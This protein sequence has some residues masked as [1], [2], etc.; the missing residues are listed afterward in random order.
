MRGGV[1]LAPEMLGCNSA[2]ELPCQIVRARLRNGLRH[3][4]GR[5]F[6]VS[7][8]AHDCADDVFQ[9]LRPVCPIGD[10]GW[11]EA[12]PLSQEAPIMFPFL[13][14]LHLHDSFIRS[15]R[16]AETVREDSVSRERLAEYQRR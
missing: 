9:Q 4:D 11:P 6:T 1:L 14:E 8:P 5:L 2:L 10:G 7:L 16:A 15:P 12:K 13:R 3:V